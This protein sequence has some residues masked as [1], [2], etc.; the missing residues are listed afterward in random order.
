MA[1]KINRTVVVTGGT[2]GIG[3]EIVRAFLAKGDR[4]F[5]AARSEVDGFGAQAPGAEFVRTD[6]RQRQEMEALM[7]RATKDS[8]RVDVMINN[9]GISIWKKLSG[10]DEEFADL[11]LET[12]LK[13][14]LWGC[15]AAAAR[16]SNGGVIINVASLAGKRGS[17]NNSV[18]CASKF[19]MVGL[20]QALAKELG[21]AGIR[22]NGVCPVYVNTQSLLTNL[23]GDHPEVGEMKGQAFLDQWGSR[24]AAL[25]RLPTGEECASLCVYLASEAAGA[26]TGQNINVDCG[27][28]PQ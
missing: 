13:G 4:V 22:V 24:S 20:T 15:Q 11:L 3:L 27:V 18:Y 25:Q 23:S 1:D 8:G 12:N 5:A 6:V 21:P 19:G 28:L 7:D 10:I 26:I 9:A 17:A 2:K 16:M 14:A